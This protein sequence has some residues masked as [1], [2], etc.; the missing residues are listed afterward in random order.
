MR[1]LW[2]TLV[3]G[4]V[5]FVCATLIVLAVTIPLGWMGVIR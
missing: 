2:D 3:A 1:F 4:V 5:M